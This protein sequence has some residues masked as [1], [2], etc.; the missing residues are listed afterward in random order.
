[1]FIYKILSSCRNDEWNI[2]VARPEYTS[3][4]LIPDDQ[5]LSPYDSFVSFEKVCHVTS[6]SVSLD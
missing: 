6:D 3:I 4:F 2:T 5:P 1:M